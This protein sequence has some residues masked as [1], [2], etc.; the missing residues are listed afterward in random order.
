MSVSRNKYDELDE[1]FKKKFKKFIKGEPNG[2]IISN[3]VLRCFET[4]Y[5]YNDGLEGLKELLKEVEGI[6]IK[7]K[8]DTRVFPEY[9]EMSWDKVED[10][11]KE[12]TVF[13]GEAYVVSTIDTREFVDEILVKCEN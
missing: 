8:V 11:P 10:I 12:L 3:I 5:N 4:D 9:M 7:Y 2:F 6:E 1:Y 13:D